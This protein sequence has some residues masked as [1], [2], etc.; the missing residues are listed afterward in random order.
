MDLQVVLPGESPDLPPERLA[1]LAAEAESFGY[2]AAW[3]PDHVLPPGPFGREY[4]G[5]Y[6]P[7]TTLAYLAA[8]TERLRLGTSVLILPLRNPF[9][10]AKQAAT[11]HRLS[12]GRLTLGLGLGWNR[13][14]FA[15]LGAEFAGRGARADDA[16]GLM[17]ALFDGASS[18]H[19]THH[20]FEAGTFEPVPATPLPIMVG[21]VSDRALARAAA[22]A[23]EWQG[24]AMTPDEF[25]VRLRTLRRLR[26]EAG[27]G[28]IRTGLRTEWTGGDR[29]ELAATVDSVRRTA[30]AGAD[31]LAVWFGHHDGFGDRMREFAAACGA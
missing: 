22:L 8:R 9:V 7:L 2:Q 29:H 4:G 13:S 15:A 23:D 27:A 31:A 21:G 30:A 3:L 10:V 11:V 1:G 18:Y 26:D 14:E 20:R 5:V 6:E 19:G 25:A 17:R 16:I 24:F 28:P 12:G